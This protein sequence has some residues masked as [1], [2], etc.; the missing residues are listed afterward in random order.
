M[1]RIKLDNISRGNISN[2]MKSKILQYQL[3]LCKKITKVTIIHITKLILKFKAKKDNLCSDTA[4]LW[5]IPYLPWVSICVSALPAKTKT[6]IKSFPTLK[7]TDIKIM[8]IMKTTTSCNI[9]ENKNQNT[10]RTE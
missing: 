4:K 2:Y 1:K 3:H 8:D 10:N 9:L 6:W 5:L 7:F